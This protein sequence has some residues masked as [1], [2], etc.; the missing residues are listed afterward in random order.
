MAEFKPDVVVHL[1]GI[2]RETP[3]RAT[4][5]KI[6]IEGT[7]NITKAAKKTGV[8]KIIYVSALGADL[9]GI[10][11]YYKSK[12]QAEEIIK[13]TGLDYTILRPAIIFGWRS[14]FTN[15][16]KFWAKILPFIPVIEKKDIKLQPVAA[17]TLAHIIAQ[18]SQNKGSKKI[19]EIVGP[20]SISVYEITKRVKEK[21]GSRK[22]I[23]PIPVFVARIAAVLGNLHFPTPITNSELKM[24]LLEDNGSN[25]KLKKDFDFKDIYFDP[26]GEYPLY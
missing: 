13:N 20:E 19:Y 5:K 11:E 8:K 17:E 21:M 14:Q 12:A 24:L 23:L 1:V 7:Q 3:P 26:M 15:R 10:T 9:K 22:V 25:E 16:L 4:Y 2:V 6:H 18:A